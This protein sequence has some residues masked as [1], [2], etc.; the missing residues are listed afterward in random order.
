VSRS[1]LTI[2]WCP[3]TGSTTGLRNCKTLKSESLQTIPFGFCNLFV[4][5]VLFFSERVL[6]C[7]PGW[8]ITWYIE[9]TGLNVMA[10]FLPYLLN[11]GDSVSSTPA[12]FPLLFASGVR[13]LDE[14][15]LSVYLLY[16]FPRILSSRMGCF[17]AYSHPQSRP[18]PE[19]GICLKR[20]KL[21]QIK[22]LVPC[23]QTQRG[24]VLFP[25]WIFQY[26]QFHEPLF[27][28]NV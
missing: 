8:C 24:H 27:K 17:S 3:A 16:Q 22:T 14:V 26:T 12:C 18:W 21:W 11:A 7:S 6:M 1:A 20:G 10:I 23:K 13:H 2:L 28:G 9:Q 4:C 19:L 25:L 15:W 5:F